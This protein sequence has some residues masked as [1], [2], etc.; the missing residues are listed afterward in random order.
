MDTQSSNDLE[1]GYQASLQDLEK[2]FQGAQPP[3][4]LK[5]PAPAM[6]SMGIPADIQARV[7]RPFGL[8]KMPVAPA[9]LAVPGAGSLLG[10]V[11]LQGLAGGAE[12]LAQGKG[13]LA[14]AKGAGAGI[15]GGLAG[16]AAAPVVKSAASPLI[17]KAA[18]TQVAQKVTDYLKEK[19]PAWAGMKTLGQMLYSQRGFNRLHEAY[20]QS[21]KD[22]VSKGAGKEL[23][24][25][26][27]VA[28]KLGVEVKGL[29][30]SKLT[31]PGMPQSVSVDAGKLAEAMTGKWKGT[32][33]GA[34]GVAAKALD[35]AGIGDP[36][37]RTAY[38]IAM[39]AGS[40]LNSAKAL[41]PSGREFNLMAAQSKLGDQ[42]AVDELRKRGMGDMIDLLLPEGQKAV[43]KGT[44]R[45]PGA[46]LGVLSGMVGGHAGGGM[47][48]ALPGGAG[49]E[50]IGQR[51]GQMLPKYG[52]LPATPQAA[53]I[54]ALLSKLGGVAGTKGPLAPSTPT[55]P[56]VLSMLGPTSAEAAT[57]RDK[58]ITPQ[59]VQPVP[60]INSRADLLKYLLD[61]YYKGSIKPP[62]SVQK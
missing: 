38:R 7:E 8:P 20:D 56:G 48:M 26:E 29:V 58:G 50:F 13:P 27:D 28:R 10:R 18:D 51:L 5:P 1:K 4:P 55:G 11:G 52:N 2:G 49:G 36:A 3:S 15:A 43:T 6:G 32:S 23:V 60:I 25:P 34:Y 31:G 47:G 19:V 41:G 54:K 44:Q 35:A 45:V 30:A 46:I 40:Y 62:G 12:A 17:K 14:A 24:V 33:K 21:L 37:A 42:K 22:V 9:A 57:S 61:Q 39:G 16:E 59:S 53:A